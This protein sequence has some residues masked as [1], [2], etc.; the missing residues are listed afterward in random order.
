MNT[1]VQGMKFTRR[2]H[3]MVIFTCQG[4]DQFITSY[5]SALLS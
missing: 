3:T 4:R 2:W 5:D 1:A